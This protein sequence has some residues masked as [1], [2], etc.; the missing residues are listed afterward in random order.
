MNCVDCL[1]VTY[2][3]QSINNTERDQETF[4]VLLDE[5]N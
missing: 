2:D 4:L 3:D 1:S 5:P